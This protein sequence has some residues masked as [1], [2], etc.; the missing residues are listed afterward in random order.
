[1]LANHSK[2]LLA[3]I[4]LTAGALNAVAQVT[5]TATPFSEGLP[6]N[7]QGRTDH[8]YVNPSANGL[9]CAEFENKYIMKYRNSSKLQILPGDHVSIF[10]KDAY[11]SKVQKGLFNLFGDT[12]EAAVLLNVSTSAPMVKKS[13]GD[14]GRLA[15]Y[16]DSISKNSP[17]N[18]SFVLSTE[19]PMQANYL[20]IDASVILFESENSVVGK[21]L[22]KQMVN[23]ATDLSP[24]A[25]TVL[26]ALGSTLFNTNQQGQ[27]STQYRMGM[28]LGST[29]DA[30][31]QPILREGDL[32]LIT[33]RNREAVIEWDKIVYDHRDGSLRVKTSE[34]DTK[35]EG[36]P[37][38][39]L[40]Y[41]VFT[42][43]KNISTGYDDKTAQ[44]LSDV[45]ETEMQRSTNAQA[46]TDAV[47]R[48]VNNAVSYDGIKSL[49]GKYNSEA[50]PQVKKALRKE[51]AYSYACGTNGLTTGACKGQKVVTDPASLNGIKRRLL[52]D[53]LFC[54]DQMSQIGSVT[55]KPD[56]SP[57]FST[58]DKFLDGLKP[59][60]ADCNSPT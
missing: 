26:N 56:Q 44:T 53:G 58:L 28:L 24:G 49:I 43:R 16:S 34:D 31:R 19:V 11:F 55:L 27:I 45:I 39:G 3:L 35:C 21:S 14:Y 1:V 22:I 42:I 15:Y 60:I 30:I 41:L 12:A 29:S 8:R 38:T 54:E 32:V 46:I 9:Y 10:L 25:S 2:S 57:D 6:K 50:N 13:P 59:G 18:A 48:H 51:L 52:A 40:D 37:L 7:A 4:L 36:P 47:M 33:S 20:S 5:T 17:V 23:L